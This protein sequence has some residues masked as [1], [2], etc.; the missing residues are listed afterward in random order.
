[1]TAPRISAVMATWNSERTLERALQSLLAQTGPVEVIVVDGAS[2]DGTLAILE[3]YRD[4]LA[5]VV[6]E[7]DRGVYDALNKGAA[8]ARGDYVYILGSDD[9]LAHESALADLLAA[10]DGADVIYGPVDVIEGNGDVRTAQ[11]HPLTRYKYFMPFSHQ[12]VIVRTELVRRH[13]FGQ[14]LASDYRQLFTLYV[15]GRRFVQTR[16]KVAVYSETGGLSDR[17]QVAATWDRLRINFALRGWRALDVL[18]FYLA[19]TAVCWLKPKLWRAL[20]LAPKPAAPR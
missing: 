5:A 14:S 8:L 19:Q 10:G 17:H 7:P 16:C 20:G 2:R 6:S 15:Q 1:M 9:K 12:G 4:R 11:P 13:P 18:P 3:R